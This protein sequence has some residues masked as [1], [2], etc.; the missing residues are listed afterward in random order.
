MIPALRQISLPSAN[1]KDGDSPQVLIPDADTVRQECVGVEAEKAMLV[2]LQDRPKPTEDSPS[3]AEGQEC[4]GDQPG[5][6]ENSK[7]ELPDVSVESTGVAL[8]S[9][10]APGQAENNSTPSLDELKVVLNVAG[11]RNEPLEGTMEPSVPLRNETEQRELGQSG[12]DMA[13]QEPTPQPR[14]DSSGTSVLTPRSGV[15]DVSC[16]ISPAADSPETPPDK[17]VSKCVD[18]FSMDVSALYRSGSPSSPSPPRPRSRSLHMPIV[19]KGT[20][21]SPPL[22]RKLVWTSPTGVQT[23]QLMPR[24]PV[25]FGDSSDESEREHD[26]SPSPSETPDNISSQKPEAKALPSLTLPLHSP[27]LVQSTKSLD[28]PTIVVTGVDNLLQ[29]KPADALDAPRQKRPHSVFAGVGQ[30]DAS[31][32]DQLESNRLREPRTALHRLNLSD[33]SDYSSTSERPTSWLGPLSG[34]RLRGSAGV[35]AQVRQLRGRGALLSVSGNTSEM[36]ELEL[37]PEWRERMGAMATTLELTMLNIGRDDAGGST[38]EDEISGRENRRLSDGSS[39]EISSAHETSTP[40]LSPPPLAW[41]DSQSEEDER[42]PVAMAPARFQGTPKILRKG[43][44]K[45]KAHGSLL[46]AESVRQA[47]ADDGV[48]TRLFAPPVAELGALSDAEGR[49]VSSPRIS[50]F[51][52][53]QQAFNHQPAPGNEQ[54]KVSVAMKTVSL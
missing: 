15:S 48:F 35:N 31:S 23:E 54:K 20:A 42:A 32:A 37:D 8:Q 9:R 24:P 22:K 11:Q 16:E 33:D 40:T 10:D 18:R 43:A 26:Q 29:D 21:R 34:S 39:E 17:Q 47:S 27:R 13:E 6:S 25:G 41:Q 5:H 38:D 28:S 1:Q 19:L 12:S 4:S 50:R 52:S 49:H 45:H 44:V 30:A 3:P 51:R 7:T 46:G 14:N 2:E 53:P 36:D